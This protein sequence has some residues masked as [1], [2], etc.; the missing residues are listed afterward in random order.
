M[1]WL[2]KG[3]GVTCNHVLKGEKG[4]SPQQL[5]SWSVLMLGVCLAYRGR[6]VA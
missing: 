4:C 5:G 6:G 1:T 3:E 2:S